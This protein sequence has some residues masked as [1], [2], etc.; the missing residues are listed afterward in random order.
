MNVLSVTKVNGM[1]K[2]TLEREY[3]FKNFYISGTISN[4]KHHSNGHYYFSL[5]DDNASID[6][7]MWGST[8]AAKG[9]GGQLENGLLVT[10]RASLN[11][12]EKAG[13]LNLI[14]Q[15]IQVGVKS[16]YQL[17]FEELKAELL[18]LGYFD[19]EH[20]QL[21]PTRA[22]CIAMVTSESGAVMHDILQVASRRNPLVK[23][24]LFSV[25]VQGEKAAPI[26][27]K[28][29]KAADQDPEIDLIIVGRGGGSM[30]D[31]W[32]F[33]ERIVVEAIYEAKTPIISAIGHETDITLSDFV[34]D[35]RAATPSQA[36]ELSVYPLSDL[37]NELTAMEQYLHQYI[38]SA[39]QEQ[40]QALAAIFNR[41][42]G[43]PA[44]TLLHQQQQKLNQFEQTLH[45][46][47]QFTI[48]NK[49]SALLKEAEKLEILNPLHLLTKGYS[50]I[51]KDNKAI[52]SIS[53]LSAED[54][55]HLTLA[56]GQV[57]ALVKEVHHG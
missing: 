26:I 8:A 23:F 11:F 53:Q 3:L 42:L 37:I 4:L 33:N 38:Q 44:L 40:K 35:V 20:K 56:D 15:D 28:G 21:L 24:K 27:A 51:E 13:R 6:T 50:K 2:R 46:T 12:Y 1:I 9:L 57:T 5:K 36:A 47:M 29:I 18:S 25:P 10:M 32:C 52:T 48:K 30:E 49:E 17:A 22:S 19:E 45:T 16:A 14:C 55:I 34:A 41:R 7:T 43:I 31:L 54:Q 39:L